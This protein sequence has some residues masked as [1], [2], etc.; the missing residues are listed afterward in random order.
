M[1]MYLQDSN[2][3]SSKRRAKNEAEVMDIDVTFDSI[4][5]GLK[6]VYK[7]TEVSESS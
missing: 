1:L 6:D 5:R 2:P 4:K 3:G 7:R